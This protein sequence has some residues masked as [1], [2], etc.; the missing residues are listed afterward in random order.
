MVQPLSPFLLIPVPLSLFVKKYTSL[1][2]ETKILYN[3][4][5][6]C[7]YSETVI[8]RA[9]IGMCQYF[10]LLT[11]NGMWSQVRSFFCTLQFLITDFWILTDSWVQLNLLVTSN[12]LIV[13][14][15]FESNGSVPMRLYVT[16]N[17][18]MLTN[19]QFFFTK[20]FFLQSCMNNQSRYELKLDAMCVRNSRPLNSCVK[21]EQKRFTLAHHP[22]LKTELMTC[23]EN[24]L[25]CIVHSKSFN[26]Y[27]ILIWVEQ[28]ATHHNVGSH[29]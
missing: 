14:L 12:N 24:C 10:R 20:N 7:L 19:M 21:K 15:Y 8:A 25:H 29:F 28:I 27:F 1:K 13:T 11:Q 23:L 2:R 18:I 16:K 5:E 9:T 17:T 3:I 22:L 4:I 26:I 6:Q